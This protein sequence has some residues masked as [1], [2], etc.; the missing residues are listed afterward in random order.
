MTK[1]IYDIEIE[2]LKIK[3]FRNSKVFTPNLTTFSLIEA[4][5]KYKIKKK[6]KILDLG[7]GSGVIGIYIKKKYKNKVDIYFSDYSS[8]AVKLITKNIKL[9]KIKGEVKKSDIFKNWSNEKFDIIINDISAIDQ[10]IAKRFWYNQYIPHQCGDNGIELSK[11]VI[12]NAKNYLNKKGFLLAPIIS[13]S[14]HKSLKKLIDKNFKS[15]ILLHKDWPAPKK[16]YKNNENKY[17]KSD[18]IK[19]FFGVYICFTQIYKI[20]T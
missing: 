5:K 3:L 8:H 4:F 15:K 16:L 12:L 19:K 1:N 2:G 17:L 7:S 20:W 11:K 9:N 10:K 13:L 14:N 18:Y 6:I